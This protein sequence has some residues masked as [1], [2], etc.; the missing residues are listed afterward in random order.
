MHRQIL[1]IACNGYI[2]KDKLGNFRGPSCLCISIREAQEII[3]Y[4]G[5][6]LVE[7]GK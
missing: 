4:S 2:G 7:D 3:K 1:R 6:E 5:C